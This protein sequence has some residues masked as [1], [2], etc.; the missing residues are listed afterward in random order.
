[1]LDKT[2]SM[3]DFSPPPAW[4]SSLLSPAPSSPTAIPGS[5]AISSVP[6]FSLASAM[7]STLSVANPLPLSSQAWEEINPHGR[8]WCRP[9][10]CPVLSAAPAVSQ[11]GG[12]DQIRPVRRHEIHCTQLEALP[13][14]FRLRKAAAAGK[15]VSFDMGAHPGQQDPQPPHLWAAGGE[16][17]R[18]PRWQEY[19]GSMLTLDPSV[20]WH[21]ST[22]MTYRSGNS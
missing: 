18:G 17:G 7:P 8:L 5:T 13:G 4:G 20:Q 2:P 21:A 11:G 3:V 6:I 1:M 19:A 14:V 15:S 22:I 10:H 12:Q 9:G 16:G